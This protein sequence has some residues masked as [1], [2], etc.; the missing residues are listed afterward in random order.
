MTG[1]KKVKFF[2]KTIDQPAF[3]QF[4]VKCLRN[5]L[6]TLFTTILCKIN[7]LLTVSLVLCRMIHVGHN[8]CQLSV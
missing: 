5:L 8:Y 3:F 2:S 7:D 4:L 1:K 6:I